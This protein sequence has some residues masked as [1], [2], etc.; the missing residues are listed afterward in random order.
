MYQVIKNRKCFDFLR[1]E[2]QER[3]VNRLGTA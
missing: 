1:L 2:E 3:I